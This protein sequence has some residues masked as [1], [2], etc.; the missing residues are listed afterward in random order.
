MAAF[1]SLVD[2][3]LP[4]NPGK[5]LA[6]RTGVSQSGS[7]LIEIN[8]P[9]PRDVTDLVLALQY[10]DTSGQWRQFEKPL[11][12]PIRAGQKQILDLGIAVNPAQAGQVRGGVVAA[13]IVR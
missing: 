5:Y 13:R 12:G 2:L 10:P 6:V 11:Q 3:D 9:T 8:N 1:A 4:E 7:L